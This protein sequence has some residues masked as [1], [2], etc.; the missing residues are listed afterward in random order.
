MPYPIYEKLRDLGLDFEVKYADEDLGHNCGK[1]MYINGE[2]IEEDKEGNYY[3][4]R[5]LWNK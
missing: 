2:T 3:W 5:N 4:A 1:F